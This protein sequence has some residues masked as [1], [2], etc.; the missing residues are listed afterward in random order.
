MG[1]DIIL[2][3]IIPIVCGFLVSYIVTRVQEHHA[4]RKKAAGTHP[5]DDSDL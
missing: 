1:G 4:E 5:P 3:A 2:A